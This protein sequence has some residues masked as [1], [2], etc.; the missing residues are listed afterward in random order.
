MATINRHKLLSKERI[1]AAFKMFD[2]D[3]NGYLTADEL[4]EIFNPGNQKAID[5]NVWKELI[6]EVDENGDGKVYLIIN[7]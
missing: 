7:M 3:G 5:E 4:Q 2:K 1:E 6:S